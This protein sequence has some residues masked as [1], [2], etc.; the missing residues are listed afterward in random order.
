MRRYAFVFFIIVALCM[1]ILYVGC[2]SGSAPAISHED[3]T[4]TNLESISNDSMTSSENEYIHG[5]TIEVDGEDYYLSG[6]A[7]GPNGEMDIPGHTWKLESENKLTGKH[8]NT[9]PSGAANWW[10]SDAGDGAL[11]YTVEAT[12]DEWTQAK[13]NEYISQGYVHYHE[14]ARVSDGTLHPTKVVWLRHTA[15]TNFTLDGGPAPDLGHK[16]T[17]GIDCEFIPN[18]CMPYSP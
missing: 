1:T 13:A 18:G 11:L 3:T 16:V 4:E 12:I 8:Y 9:G 14:L 10:S 15:V 17:E 2:D 5:I 6:P 7:D